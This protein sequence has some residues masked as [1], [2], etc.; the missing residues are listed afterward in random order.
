MDKEEQKPPIGRPTK[1]TDY[2]QCKIQR[3]AP[4]GLTNKQLAAAIDVTE[5]TLYNWQLEH[6]AFFE[7]LTRSKRNA[8]KIVAASMYQAA[9]GFSVE[10]DKIFCTDGKVTTV[11][12]IKNYPPDMKAV[13]LWLKN[14]E[15]DKWRD[16]IDHEH[17]G[18]G[19]GPIKTSI[20]VVFIGKDKQSNG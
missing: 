2:I 16:K 10:E 9:I 4:L 13:A 3:L 11:R 15:P 17:T 14:R 1:F 19:G 7:E 20:E 6:K 18:E 12:T 5:T 8:N